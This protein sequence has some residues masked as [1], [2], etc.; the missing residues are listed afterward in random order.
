M[1][2]TRQAHSHDVNAKAGVANAE[3]WGTSAAFGDY[4]KMAT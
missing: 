3:R 1:Q 2:Q 4:D